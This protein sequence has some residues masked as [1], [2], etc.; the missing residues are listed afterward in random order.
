MPNGLYVV[1]FHAHLQDCLTQ[2]MLCKEDRNSELFKRAAPLI[3]QVAQIGEPFYSLHVRS[4]VAKYHNRFS[5]FYK[6]MGHVVLIEIL[7]LFK[8]YGVERL[9]HAMEKHGIDHAVILSLEPL[10][11]T[12]NILELIK[13]FR[14]KLSVFA[15][16]H[17]NESDPV[18]YFKN[19]VDSGAVSGLKIHPIV[20]GFACGELYYKVKDLVA[21][22]SERS[23][24]IMIHTGH[25]PVDHLKGVS[26]C[27]DIDA[28]EPLFSDFP[29]AKFIL[30]HIGWESWRRALAMG[31]RYPN[32][33]VETSWQSASVIRR[34]VD[35]LGAERVIF[36]S[37]YPL[38]NQQL[39][40][41]QLRNALTAKEF[42]LVASVNAKRLLRLDERAASQ[43]AS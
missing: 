8:E 2:E 32:I 34:A 23:L 11:S 5:P 6:M 9:L 36:G 40:I 28:L 29:K 35:T 41:D 33:W 10:T 27:S 37:D 24:P 19:F 14:D 1:D 7:R 3:E 42:V 25:I 31:K 38:F 16:V 26:G 17:R 12:Q 39:A 30:G 20:G 4:F 15:S 18:G 43:A 22:A 13:P 21:F